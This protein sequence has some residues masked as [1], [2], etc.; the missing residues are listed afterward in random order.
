MLDVLNALLH[1][2]PGSE[3]HYLASTGW[4]PD[5]PPQELEGYEEYS[6]RHAAARVELERLIGPAER[7]LPDDAEWFQAWYPEAFAA[8][9]WRR[10]GKY[11]CLAAEHHD[12]ETPI[13]LALFCL[14]EA[15]LAERTG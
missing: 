14:T 7:S 2:R 5:A 4:L 12:K 8:A 6:S 13:S 10:E 11:V 9:V 3:P 1:S 15:E